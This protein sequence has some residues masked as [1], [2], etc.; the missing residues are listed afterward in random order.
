MVVALLDDVELELEAGLV[1]VD[2]RGQVGVGVGE[3]DVGG[4]NQEVREAGP[5]NRE[6]IALQDR[7]VGRLVSTEVLIVVQEHF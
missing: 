5:V 4:N 3:Q 7:R 6:R 2:R 1:V